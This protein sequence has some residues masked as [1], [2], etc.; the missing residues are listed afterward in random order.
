MRYCDILREAAPAQ[1]ETWKTVT[2]QGRVFHIGWQNAKDASNRINHGLALEDGGPLLFSALGQF[3]VIFEEGEERIKLIAPDASGSLLVVIY[4][5]IEDDLSDT[6]GDT[7]IR[8]I[9]VYKA[10]PTE[11]M[12]YRKQQMN[13][14][15]K[16][17]IS[18]APPE[19]VEGSSS[20][21]VHQ[22]PMRQHLP[23]L[24]QKADERKARAAARRANMARANQKA[25]P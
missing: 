20:A 10:G 12:R 3:D 5:E 22:Q 14:D 13:E 18:P 9:S 2:F 17:E 6:S 1:R 4:Q 7:W 21:P 8:V 15:D 11:T 25:K 23:Y 19:D 16:R 24:L